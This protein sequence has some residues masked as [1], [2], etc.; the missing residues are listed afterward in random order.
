MD[1]STWDV[2]VVGGGVSGFTAAIAASRNG[3]K[4]LLIEK[5]GALGGTM[6][7]VLV[8]PMM[9]FHSFVQQTIRGIPQEVVDRLKGM[10]GSPGHILDETGYSAT[11]TPFDN[12]SLKL[13]AQ[14]MVLESGAQILLHTWV[15]GTIVSNHTLQGLVVLNKGGIEKLYARVI[16]DASGDADVAYFAGAP[17]E[18]GRQQDGLVQPVSLIFRVGPI[19]T[20]ALIEYITSH[21]KEL[22]PKTL[23]QKYQEQDYHFVNGFVDILQKAIKEGE[24]SLRREEVLFGSTGQPDEV[25]IN[26]SRIYGI[27]PLDAW[28]LTKA[29]LLG[30]E[31]MFSLMSFLQK[32]IPGFKN[33]HIQ[34]AGSRVGV[35]ESRRVMGDY[36][37]TY[38]DLAACRHFPDAVVRNSYEIDV[39]AETEQDTSIDEALSG[40]YYEIPYR[41]LVPRKVEQLLIAGR[42]ISTTHKAQGSTRTSPTCMALGQ[43]AGTAAALSIKEETSPRYLNHELLRKTL[44]SQGAFL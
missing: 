17:I 5:E 26:M 35:R 18:I 31:Q 23:I 2:I 15:Q 22:N 29:E 25:I 10:G 36:V 39:H 1:N 11:V 6:A 38:E 30:R 40:E 19:D 3:A 8:G 16:I 9:T 41:C 14:R 12:E 24:L 33:A 32:R 28:D 7:N 44:I 20:K 37:L 42:C 21:P 27:D 34:A 43:A 13:V 4:T